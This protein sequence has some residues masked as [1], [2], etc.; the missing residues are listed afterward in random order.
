M[1]SGLSSQTQHN[2]RAGVVV[3]HDG[4]GSGR[5]LVQLED[6][7]TISLKP[8]NVRRLVRCTAVELSST[9]LN[10]R[11]GHVVGM[12]EQSGR[13]HV[14]IDG[15]VVA[16][17]LQNTR[18]DEGTTIVVNRLM[19]ASQH[20]GSKGTVVDNHSDSER[21]LVQLETGAMI[22]VRLGNLTPVL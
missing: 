11:C 14:S 19:S 2:G 21:C 22:K 5:Y 7:S 6:G 20:N 16:L 9:Y 1:I 15:K 18:L 12:D 17:M 4:G 10:G 3:A 13:V 8:E